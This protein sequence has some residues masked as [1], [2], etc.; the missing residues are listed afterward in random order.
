M[1]MHI[2]VM[3]SKPEKKDVKP[4]KKPNTKNRVV[5][6]FDKLA[7][8]VGSMYDNMGKSSEEQEEK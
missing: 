6:F 8:N 5:N 3:P 4:R 2:V 1:R 7:G